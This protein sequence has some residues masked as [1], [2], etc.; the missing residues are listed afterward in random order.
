MTSQ[1]VTFQMLLAGVWTTVPLYNAAGV[2]IV[3]GHDP[4]GS[5]PR[6]TTV[7]CEINN[8]T[9]DYDPSLPASLLYG[10]A[11]R[12]TRTRI[13]SN[14]NSRVWTEAGQW[15]PDRTP[16]HVPGTLRGRAWVGMT[17]QGV[18]NRIGLWTDPLRS[19]LYRTISA[20]PTC[21]GHWPL[22]DSRGA[23]RAAATVSTAAKVYGGPTF[24]ETDSPNGASTSMQA[25]STSV[26]TGNFLSAS[27][28][29][30]WQVA[31]SM[32]LDSVPTSST[33]VG[34]LN[35]TTSLG[36]RWY[37]NVNNTTYQFKVDA[38]D[39]TNLFDSGAVLFG[40]G[41]EPDKWVTFRLKASASGGTVT[42]EPAWYAYGADIWGITA[43]FSGA[44]GALRSWREVGDP[45]LDSP[46]F[47][48]V[49][50]VTGVTD[51]L[52]SFTARRAFD[53][54]RDER[55][56]DRFL[57][58]CGEVGVQGYVIGNTAET[59]PMG[60]QAPVTFMQN[61][62]EMRDTDDCRIDD[63]RFDIALTLRTRR[64]MTAQTPV[65]TLNYPADIAQPFRKLI[66]DLSIRNVVTVSN[67]DGSDLTL[68][69]TAG[70]ASI[71]PP[72][73]GVGSVA[74]TIDVNVADEDAQLPDLASWRLAKTTLT[75]PRYAEVTVDLLA[76]PGLASSV[77]AVREGDLIRVAGYTYDPIDLIAVGIKEQIGPGAVWTVTFQT[78]PA[79]PYRVGVYDDAT[80]RWD[81]DSTIPAGATSTAVSLVTNALTAGDVWT[82]TAG[83][84]P[85]DAD[86]AG[87]VVRVTAVSAA[88]A[89][90]TYAQTLTVTRSINGVVKAI[91]ANS[92][93]HVHDYRRW[94]V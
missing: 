46:H 38:A 4:Y 57:R 45:G 52:L 85:F 53:G 65:L 27:T 58:L 90:P 22:E 39:G 92:E 61:L 51:D 59:Q 7:E 5:W 30:G 94:G 8:D 47:S 29:A 13:F 69:L 1:A 33:Y 26:V 68:S 19:P 2:S 82:R 37:W 80:W 74:Q 11:G 34:M 44:M 91:P 50:A 32:R 20:R 41:S 35:W 71:Q 73:A 42:V 12:N 31:F 56:G 14:G 25:S 64:A 84:L 67:R 10:I 86:V 62:T 60:P 89:A 87:E 15:E 28:T 79:D 43:T 72:P 70:P 21:I 55:V 63:E 36:Q 78:E 49:Y 48:H 75:A 40:A 6:P 18:L 66:D 93:I 54:Y 17:G 88:G 3:R 9:L 76:D 77:M 23:T 16:E 81:A 24:G 83:S